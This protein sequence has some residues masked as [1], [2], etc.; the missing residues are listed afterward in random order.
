MNSFAQ[1]QLGLL[2]ETTAIRDQI[3]AAIGDADLAYALPGN[4]VNLGALLVE[5]GETQHIYATSFRTLKMDWRLYGQSEPA[6]KTSVAGLKVWFAGLDTELEAAL[7][8]L[9]EEQIQTAVVD[10]GGF[11][12]PITVQYHIYRE[13][14]LI[15]FAKASLYLKALGKPLSEQVRT[16]IG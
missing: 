10:R 16:W 3:L 6:L 7:R 8:D 5:L 13:A 4:N 12:P 2:R 14:L 15:A 1:Q 11:T 9:T